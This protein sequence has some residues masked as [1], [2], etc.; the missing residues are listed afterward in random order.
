MTIYVRLLLCSQVKAKFS[1]DNW[2]NRGLNPSLGFVQCA[3]GPS[4]SKLLIWIRILQIGLSLKIG[5]FETEYVILILQNLDPDLV[6]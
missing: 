2:K 4:I 6:I 5:Y 3:P 1:Q